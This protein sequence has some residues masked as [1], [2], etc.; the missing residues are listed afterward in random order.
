[1]LEFYRQQIDTIDAEILKLLAQRLEISKKIWIYKQQNNLPVFQSERREQILHNRQEQ[2]AK[3][4][5]SPLFIKDLRNH[6]HEESLLLQ[7]HN[8]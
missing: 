6:I 4:W 8:G 7:N 3:I 2:A 5:L 1:M